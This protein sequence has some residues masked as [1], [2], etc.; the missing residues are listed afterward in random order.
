MT[1]NTVAALYWV[2]V[3][4]RSL[5]LNTSDGRSV[6]YLLCFQ[7]KQVILAPFMLSTAKCQVTK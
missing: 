3:R 1:L 7:F 4:R 2:N 5:G 6:I